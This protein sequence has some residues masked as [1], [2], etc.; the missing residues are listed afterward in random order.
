[1]SDLSH[2]HDSNIRLTSVELT[3]I[4]KDSKAIVEDAVK[5][6]D[7]EYIFR[8][9]DTLVRFGQAAWFSMAHTLYCARRTWAESFDSE[10]DFIQTAAARIG[11]SPQTILRMVEIWE[12]VFERPEHKQSR[13][14]RLLQ[15]PPSGLWYIKAASKEGQLTEDD[16][17]AIEKAP[18]KAELRAIAKGV[19]GEYGRAKT[20]LKIMIEMETGTLYIAKGSGEYKV[21]GHLNTHLQEEDDVIA[22]G[23]E[24]VTSASGIFEK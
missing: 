10:H 5:N 12:W 14:N 21:L 3:Q 2:P 13:V 17:D 16:W 20:A 8:Y 1:M 23:I 4:K 22:A 9:L 6:Q 7:P 15:K 24:R 18:N 11:R 19:R